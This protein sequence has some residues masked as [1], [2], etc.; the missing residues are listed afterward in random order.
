MSIITTKHRVQIVSASL[1]ALALYIV[2]PDVAPVPAGAAPVTPPAD[3]SIA[4]RTGQVLGLSGTPNLWVMDDSG[5]AHYAGD[6]GALAGRAVDWSAVQPVTVAQ[7]RDVPRGTPW[8]SAALVRIGEAIYLPAFGTGSETPVL[9]H[10][11]SP[12]D[13]TLLGVNADNYSQL[14]LDRPAWE[15]RYGFATTTLTFDDF[16]L[17]GTPAVGPSLPEPATT[18]VAETPTASATS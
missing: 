17:D 8:L 4:A 6:P 3:S 15:Q 11:K 5:V 14:V 7:L 12:Q 2:A 16:R 13:L 10:V 1:T 18:D 9:L